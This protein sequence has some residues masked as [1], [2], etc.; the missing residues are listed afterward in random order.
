MNNT[1]CAS[2]TFNTSAFFNTKFENELQDSFLVN[3]NVTEEGTGELLADFWTSDLFILCIHVC[4][5]SFLPD[6]VMSKS[7]TVSI[8]FKV[9]KVTFLELPGYIDYGSVINGKAS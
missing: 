4:H 1:G 2:L 5:F 9:G 6:V 7:T 8:T 3:V